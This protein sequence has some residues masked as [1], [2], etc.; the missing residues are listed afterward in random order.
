[1]ID[2]VFQLLFRYEA[3]ISEKYIAMFHGFSQR[4][5]IEQMQHVLRSDR[6]FLSC[7]ANYWKCIPLSQLV[8]DKPISDVEFV[9]TDIE[10]TGSIRGKDRIIDIAAIKIRDNKE[11]GRFESLVQPGLPITYQISRLTGIKNDTVKNAQPIE[12]VLPKY[13]DFMQD[14]IF[15]AHNSL[16]DYLFINSEINRLDLTPLQTQMEICTFRMAKKILPDLRAR[17]VSGL[18]KYFNYSLEG[19]HRAMPDVLATKYYF[20]QFI[21]IL[22]KEGIDT[23]HQLI[24]FQK[25]KITNKNLNK[26]IKKFKKNKRNRSIS[27][28]W[29]GDN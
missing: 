8:L 6:R 19:R 27:H 5:Q 26:K 9:I 22:S 17:G 2:S 24:E 14:A 18:A 20:E 29:G 1:M 7:Q 25:D 13:I 23:L 16:F 4:S 28:Y 15:V 10:T 11:I 21:L 12:E 3:P